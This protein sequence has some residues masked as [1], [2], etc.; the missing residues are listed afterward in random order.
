MYPRLA[1]TL[2]DPAGIGPEVILKALTDPTV[3]DRCQITVVGTRQV[4]RRTY[5]RL[6]AITSLADPNSLDLLEVPT[7]DSEWEWG[8]GNRASG[9]ASFAYLSA[10]L[11]RTLAGEFHGIVTGPIAKSLWKAAGFEYPGQTEVLAK[12][13]G[14]ERFGMLF[15]ARSPHNGWMLRTLLATTHIP[16]SQVSPVL[17]PELLALKLD[18]FV[19]CLQRDF[20]IDRP[21][22][23]ISGLNP[24]SGEEGQLGTE[25]RDWLIPW[26]EDER[27]HRPSVQLDGPVPPDTLW[28]KPGQAWYA[29]T[30]QGT[31]PF[32]DCVADGYLAMYHD[33]GL[34]PVKLMAFDRAVNTTIGLPFI[35]TSPDHGTAFDIAGRGIAD[36]T[37]MK[38]AIA[39]AAQLSERRLRVKNSASS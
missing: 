11:D 10:A 29:S 28:V 34:I 5:D 24:H 2:G 35:R 26:L 21:R 32:F 18:L 12:R 13:A 31:N 27:S 4:L 20:G 6:A 19:E 15:A 16:L 17:T 30:Q 9:G 3:L 7:E 36:A 23:A 22:I 1:I 39:L 8:R 25:E 33:Q 14:V 37:S 38:S